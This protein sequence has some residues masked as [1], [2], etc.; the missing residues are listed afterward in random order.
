MWALEDATADQAWETVK[1]KVERLIEKLVP[2]DE[3]G[4]RCEK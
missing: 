4:Y 3:K 1:T 2:I